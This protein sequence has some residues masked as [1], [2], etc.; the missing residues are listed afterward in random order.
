MGREGE[1][2]WE[3]KERGQ[4][5]VNTSW[6]PQIV[7]LRSISVL[8]ASSYMT[9]TEILSGGGGAAIC[10]FLKCIITNDSQQ[11]SIFIT[12]NMYY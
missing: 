6:P 5:V 7:Q 9:L 4:K 1:G 10:Y 3:V 11:F 12:L 8:Q 2:R